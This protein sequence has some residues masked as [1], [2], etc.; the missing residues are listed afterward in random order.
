M[1]LPMLYQV[2]MRA[3]PTKLVNQP[4][5]QNKKTHR[6]KS[7]LKS[8]MKHDQTPIRMVVIKILTI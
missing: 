7:S 1:S 6:I 8:K 5:R 2:G 3:K 4:T